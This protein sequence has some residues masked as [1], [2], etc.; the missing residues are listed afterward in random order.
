MDRENVFILGSSDFAGALVMLDGGLSCQSVSSCRRGSG[1][2]VIVAIRTIGI[3]HT[4]GSSKE[5]PEQLDGALN[6]HTVEVDSQFQLIR[7]AEL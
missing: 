7:L 6:I 4:A 1:D 2:G 3:S 5:A